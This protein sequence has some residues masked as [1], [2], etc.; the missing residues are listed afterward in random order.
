MG[1]PNF[2]EPQTVHPSPFA[3][4]R[5]GSTE[6]PPQLAPDPGPGCQAQ[7]LIDSLATPQGVIAPELLQSL[8]GCWTD[9]GPDNGPARPVSAS[10]RP[11]DTMDDYLHLVE[12]LEAICPDWNGVQV[13]NNLRALAGFDHAN[14]Q[15]MLGLDR[16][17][18]ADWAQQYGHGLTQGSDK[19]GRHIDLKLLKTLLLQ[20]GLSPEDLAALQRMSVH[21]DQDHGLVTDRT[22]KQLA[23]S[24]VLT[25]LSAGVYRNRRTPMHPLVSLGVGA[26]LDNLHAMTL[27]G[28]LG[29]S[30]TEDLMGQ[31]HRADRHLIGRDTEASEPELTGDIDGYL[32]GAHLTEQ[33]GQRSLAE[34]GERGLALSALLRSYYGQS[35]KE[36]QPAAKGLS[37]QTRFTH[38]S[39]ELAAATQGKTGMAE[40][41][42][43]TSNF[44]DVY[45]YKV[46]KE[47]SMLGRLDGF[48]VDSSTL[49]I[50]SMVAVTEFGQWLHGE[51]STEAARLAGGGAAIAAVP[52]HRRPRTPGQPIS[53][54]PHPH[55]AEPSPRSPADHPLAAE[56]AV[57]GPPGPAGNEFFVRDLDELPGMDDHH[58]P[59]PSPA[60][61]TSPEPTPHR[62]AGHST[63]FADWHDGVSA[64]VA[65]GE[66]NQY[67]AY[68][69]EATAKL[70]GDGFKFATGRVLS[71]LIDIEA[72][73]FHG[74][75]NPHSFNPAS[76]ARGLTQFTP[77]TW[78]EMRDKPGTTLNEQYHTLQAQGL[79]ASEVHRQVE[80]LKDNPKMSIMA[81]VEY[82]LKN[83]SDLAVV[84]RI[85]HIEKCPIKLLP[86]DKLYRY[87]YLAH[88]EGPRGILSYLHVEK[89]GP[90]ATGYVGKGKFNINVPKPEQAMWWQRGEAALA[91][92]TFAS[93]PA[94]QGAIRDKAYQL[95][96]SAYIERGREQWIP[97]SE[98]AP[99]PELPTA[100]ACQ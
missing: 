30:A 10:D 94:R 66:Q 63:M 20:R 98:T 58:E 25:G 31:H 11:Q 74:H 34:K 9:P 73:K 87:L 1:S 69:E 92:E 60:P 85:E 5:A 67:E 93:E 24:H 2:E 12:R 52:K 76:K 62:R 28:D 7:P 47:S 51:Q 88:H 77:G 36:P 91:G 65:E 81:A 22:G 4:T 43:Q 86:E 38:M 55:L 8:F 89:C 79:S 15:T 64:R 99:E 90:L 3:P 21:S 56:V 82:A 39:Q 54:R 46:G 95:W 78:N 16:L 13:M 42:Q 44:I 17:L 32:L 45:K 19:E 50:E 29:Q 72:S 96:L 27:A 83:L 84:E 80:Q 61:T 48:L 71:A 40:L 26:P 49:S 53:A 18:D 23:T 35:G 57:G 37:A 70:V 100:N 6:P 97:L 33:C 68:L 41:A 59:Q 14:A 75:W